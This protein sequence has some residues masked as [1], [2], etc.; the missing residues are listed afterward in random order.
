MRRRPRVLIVED[1]TAVAHTLAMILEMDGYAVEV[2]CTAADAVQLLA[3]PA[4]FDAVITDLQMESPD[5]GFTV[6]RAARQLK[7]KP[8]IVVSTG[9][10][11][12]RNAEMAWRLHVDHIVFKPAAV[13][14][15]RIAIRRLLSIRSGAKDLILR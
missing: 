5:A 2:T 10:A 9:Y 4:R 13:D 7:P 1:E 14:E 6:V 12:E 11:T 8:V 15:I 3:K